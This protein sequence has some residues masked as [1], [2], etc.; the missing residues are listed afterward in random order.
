[1]HI[2]NVAPTRINKSLTLAA[3]AA[4]I[5]LAGLVAGAIQ[6]Y[7]RTTGA[8]IF[9]SWL[10]S[11]A[12]S[13]QEGNLLSAV[14]KQSRIL[15]S[16]NFVTSIKLVETSGGDEGR[17]LLAFGPAFSDN[18]LPEATGAVAVTARGLFHSQ[19]SY[20]FPENRTMVLILDVRPKVAI[21][22]F[23]TVLAIMSLL[24][25][26]ALYLLS[27]L[28]RTEE[29]K[30]LGILSAALD[31]LVTQSEPSESLTRGFPAI[32]AT[33]SDLKTKVNHL[34]E[35]RAEK[36]KTATIAHMAQNLAH[37]IKN[38]LI[39]FDFALQASNYL[40]FAASRDQMARSLTTI[41]NILSRM[42]IGAESNVIRPSEVTLNVGLIVGD[43]GRI[44]GTDGTKVVAAGVDA[45][46][47]F[48]DAVAVERLIGNLVKNAKES[49]AKVIEIKATISGADLA[50]AVTDNGPGIP[51]PLLD[52]LFQRGSTL[53]KVGGSGIGLHNVK[54]IAEGH[55]GQVSHKR[56]G[57]ETTFTVVLPNTVM[58]ATRQNRAT[59]AY[60]VLSLH[61]E[62][63]VIEA[64]VIVRLKTEDRQEA[65]S[66]ALRS[67]GFAVS[68]DLQAGT[69]HA[70]AY[71]DLDIDGRSYEKAGVRVMIDD[72]DAD[73][74]KVAALVE[75]I[76]HF[77]TRVPNEEVPQ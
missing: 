5:A 45:V 54:D 39:A 12:I 57:G 48:L 31:D 73:V 13:I 65:I 52:K 17:P 28:Q 6:I 21:W 1:M 76:Y 67:R 75:R 23:V 50:L 62:P 11:E 71:L 22:A 8:E 20:R 66:H 53:G 51:A 42:S 27:R 61:P 40:E 59:A 7:V 4:L 10:Q 14:S 72:P 63:L 9:D 16:S 30:R 25:T 77:M 34:N 19:M 18:A 69:N 68:T 33:W 38:P 15:L 56:S 60:E 3:V 37:D 26:L 32:T 36:I 74:E 58:T 2:A 44:Y 55:G 35:E 47:A 70:I 46:P 43:L 49:G 29:D 41:R 24:V 64:A